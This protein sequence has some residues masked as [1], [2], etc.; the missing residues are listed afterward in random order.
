VAG[1]MTGEVHRC[2]ICN[3]MMNFNPQT[4]MWFCASCNRYQM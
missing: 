1:A 3:S 2:Q 4:K